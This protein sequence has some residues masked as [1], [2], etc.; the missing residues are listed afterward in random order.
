MFSRDEKL[1][2]HS[3]LWRRRRRR[4]R[5]GANRG[6]DLANLL[7][8]MDGVF[9]LY[10]KFW[11]GMKIFTCQKIFSVAILENLSFCIEL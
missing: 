11:V 10:A 8:K 3:R 1:R 6:V 5:R 2:S 9:E 4:R 7:G